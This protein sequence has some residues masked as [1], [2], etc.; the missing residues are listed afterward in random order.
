MLALCE[1][2]NLPFVA[3]GYPLAAQDAAQ[4]EASSSSAWTMAH[5]GASLTIRSRLQQGSSSRSPALN[6]A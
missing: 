1:S 3:Q 4:Q 2:L 6:S 5:G